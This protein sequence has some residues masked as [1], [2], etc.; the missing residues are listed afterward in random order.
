MIV[1]LLIFII[2]LGLGF[3]LAKL[4]SG[5][6]AGQAGVLPSWRI[7]IK[8]YIFW[9]HHWLIGLIELVVCLLFQVKIIFVY[10]LLLGIIIQGLTYKDFYYVFFQKDKYPF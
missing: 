1:Q 3:Y 4:V 7:N 9:P 6:K 10:G 2:S 5:K 8:N